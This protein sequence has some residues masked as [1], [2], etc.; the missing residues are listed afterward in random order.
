MY[1]STL[2]PLAW[3]GGI[4]VL[5]QEQTGITDSNHPAHGETDKISPLDER[6][7]QS[8][9]ENEIT[10]TDG[11]IVEKQPSGADQNTA[12]R[13]LTLDNI[14]KE[15]E[16]RLHIADA[17]QSLEEAMQPQYIEVPNAGL[18]LLAIWLP[19]LF[20]MLG[21]LTEDRKDLKDTEARVR[22]IFIL[23]R[24]VTD[25][26]QEYKEQELA[27]NRILTGCPFQVPLPK[28]LELTD[29]EIQTTESMLSG[30]KNNWDK[31]RN[32]SVKGFRH[33]FIERPGRLEQRE[34]KWVLYVENRAYDILLDSLPWSYRLVRLPWL[35]KRINVVW[36]D[37]EEFDF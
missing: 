26:P 34:D 17:E 8:N 27:F 5:V 24:L 35:K 25:E 20:G 22:A 33:S 23:Q 21:L 36:Q 37:K 1:I 15:V 6:H 16:T 10:K 31:L 7:S 9:T 29:N 28:T 4:P 2:A 3:K 18:C 32:T 30:V 14:I 13:Q 11:S 19:R 12:E